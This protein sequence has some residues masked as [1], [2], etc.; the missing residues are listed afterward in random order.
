MHR[1]HVYVKTA[2]ALSIVLPQEMR[3]GVLQDSKRPAPKQESDQAGT[4][5]ALIV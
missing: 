4:E 2:V 5:Y 1:K 3:N